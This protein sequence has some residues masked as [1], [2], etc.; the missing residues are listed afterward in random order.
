MSEIHPVRDWQAAG[1][2]KVRLTSPRPHRS[3]TLNLPHKAEN[4]LNLQ[5]IFLR[6]VDLLNA[7]CLVLRSP[8][9]ATLSLHARTMAVFSLLLLILAPAVKGFGSN[10]TIC[11]SGSACNT[12]S[13]PSSTL[14]PAGDDEA[15]ALAPSTTSEYYK[16]EITNEK[17]PNRGLPRTGSGKCT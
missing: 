3:C 14:V 11:G 6:G 4:A 15:P 17:D 2:L 8:S 1:T 7:K 12:P 9:I 5:L 16:W 13:S 10:S